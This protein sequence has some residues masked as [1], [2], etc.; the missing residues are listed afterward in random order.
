MAHKD[1]FLSRATG[2]PAGTDRAAQAESGAET[3]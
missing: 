1:R 2:T 3:S